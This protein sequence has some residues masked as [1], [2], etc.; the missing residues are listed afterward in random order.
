[1]EPRLTV[2]Q[3]SSIVTFIIA[4]SVSFMLMPFVPDPLMTIMFV[5]AMFFLGAACGTPWARPLSVGIIFAI[6]G[7]VVG[8][9]ID[10]LF[11][12][13]QWL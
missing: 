12:S 8:I 9:C 1:M 11:F 7:P 10:L 4:M 2:G 5:F 6:L 3:A 13:D